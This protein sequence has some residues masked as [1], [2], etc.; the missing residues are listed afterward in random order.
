MTI[1]DATIKVTFK[2]EGRNIFLRNIGYIVLNGTL[3]ETHF[4]YNS[5]TKGNQM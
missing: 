4:Q 1:Y 5:G 2:V 3:D